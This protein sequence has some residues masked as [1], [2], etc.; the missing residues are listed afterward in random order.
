MMRPHLVWAYS[1]LSESM[2]FRGKN[3]FV[4]LGLKLFVTLVTLTGTK[5]LTFCGAG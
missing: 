5:T 2:Q 1:G 4:A 3:L